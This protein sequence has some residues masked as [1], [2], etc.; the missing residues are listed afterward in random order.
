LGKKELQTLAKRMN[1]YQ[2]PN[3]GDVRNLLNSFDQ[4]RDGVINL[5]DFKRMGL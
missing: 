2:I 3:K 5:E 1:K 4:D